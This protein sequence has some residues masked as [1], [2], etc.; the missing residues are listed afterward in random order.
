[1]N[2]L[3]TLCLW[4]FTRVQAVPKGFPFETALLTGDEEALATAGTFF[5][6][7]ADDGWVCAGVDGGAEF[8]VAA[9]GAGGGG[10]SR[11]T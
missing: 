11:R 1:M 6:N 2:A 5:Q 4:G 9:A 8:G 7:W 10:V 3:E